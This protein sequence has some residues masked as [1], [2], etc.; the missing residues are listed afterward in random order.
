[1]DP[2]SSNLARYRKSLAAPL[3]D[4]LEIVMA[5]LFRQ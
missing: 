3:P 2:G 5:A 4:A 1:M